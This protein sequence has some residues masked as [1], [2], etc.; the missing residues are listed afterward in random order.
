MTNRNRDVP[1][2]MGVAKPADQRQ[3]SGSLSGVR[4]VRAGRVGGAP[5]AVLTNP[6]RFCVSAGVA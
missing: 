2:G 4:V 3:D 1:L 6:G 5:D